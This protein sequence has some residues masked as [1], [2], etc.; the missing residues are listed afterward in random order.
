MFPI[1]ATLTNHVPGPGVTFRESAT[2][3]ENEPAE[4]SEPVTVVTRGLPHIVGAIAEEPVGACHVRV[5]V[6]FAYAGVTA[7]ETGTFGGPHKA[8]S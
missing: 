6:P 1:S 5:K 4:F 2:D 7:A 3:V 8:N